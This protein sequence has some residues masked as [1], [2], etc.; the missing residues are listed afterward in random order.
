MAQ[1]AQ[2]AFRVALMQIGFDA[3]R[4]QAII[5]LNASMLPC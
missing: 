1:A 2:N 5:E 4:A 3:P